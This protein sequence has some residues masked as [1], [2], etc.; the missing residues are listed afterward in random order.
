MARQ[1]QPTVILF[2]QVDAIAARRRGEAANA[3]TERVVNQLLAEMD[4]L[5]ASSQV[6]VV[7]ATNRRD[8]LDPA[9]LRPGRLGLEI[10][11][12]LPDQA[13]RHEIVKALLS[14]LALADENDRLEQEIQSI[15]E[16]TEGFSGAELAAICER[17]KFI[18]LRTGNYRKDITLSASHLRAALAQLL[19]ERAHAAAPLA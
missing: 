8:L 18:A 9:L 6:I 5:R 3:T 15:A 2:D 16:A 4:G 17:A 1:V 10:Y 7:A 12:G 13:E 11:V 19:Q 14:R